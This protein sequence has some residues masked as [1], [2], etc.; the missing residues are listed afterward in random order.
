LDPP[1]V[2]A[3][4]LWL[5]TRFSCT[6]MTK[7]ANGKSARDAVRGSILAGAET[8]AVPGVRRL[9]WINGSPPIGLNQHRQVGSSL[10]PVGSLLSVVDSFVDF[11]E[12]SPQGHSLEKNM[13]TYEIIFGAAV[14]TVVLVAVAGAF[15]QR[16]KRFTRSSERSG[17]AHDPDA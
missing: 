16:G 13:D 15:I 4:Q 6:S 17:A 2:A 1:A 11:S 9:I 3:S 7:R 14:I 12:R 8:L 10:D 5:G